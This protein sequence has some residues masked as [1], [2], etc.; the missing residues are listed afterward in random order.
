MVTIQKGAFVQVTQ[1][2]YTD[3]LSTPTIS[4]ELNIN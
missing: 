3:S 4:I 2:D 1:R